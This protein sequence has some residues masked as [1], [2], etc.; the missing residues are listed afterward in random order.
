MVGARPWLMNYN[1]PLKRPSSATH[2]ITEHSSADAGSIEQKAGST[3]GGS[4]GSSFGGSTVHMAGVTGTQVLTSD[5]V[6]G[7]ARCCSVL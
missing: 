2:T 6:S 3:G 5:L 4:N 7:E 1:V